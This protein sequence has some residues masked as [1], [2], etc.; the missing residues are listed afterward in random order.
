[1]RQAWRAPDHAHRG[2]A[3]ANGAHALVGDRTLQHQRHI[4]VLRVKHHQ[5]AVRERRHGPRLV[6]GHPAHGRHDS[7]VVD[8]LWPRS[9]TS[10][11][12]AHARETPVAGVLDWSQG[13]CAL[14]PPPLLV[15]L[16]AS[17][18]TSWA[19]YPFV[20]TRDFAPKGIVQNDLAIGEADE[21]VQALRATCHRVHVQDQRTHAQKG[22]FLQWPL[23]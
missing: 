23:V 14:A 13:H 9:R 3:A 2:R 16:P 6:A 19:A 20:E 15:P 12:V 22:Q 11:T 21:H 4:L 1:M 5:A 18:S 17:P 8:A 7:L 10:G